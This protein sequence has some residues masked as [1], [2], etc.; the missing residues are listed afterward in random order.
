[1][2][3]PGTLT[4]TS[5]HAFEDAKDAPFRICKVSVRGKFHCEL[6]RIGQYPP[7]LHRG[8]YADCVA[9]SQKVAA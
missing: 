8:T 3:W 9:A 2:K 7:P 5:P 4:A 6:W 1:M